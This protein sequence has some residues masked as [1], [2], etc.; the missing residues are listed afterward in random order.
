MIPFEKDKFNI[1]NNAHNNNDHLG[2]NRTYNKI[3]ENGYFLDNI[4]NYI[5]NFIGN[6][7]NWIKIKAG[8]KP[9]QRQK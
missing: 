1:L 2:I 5:K 7:P 6:C 8:K 4:I 9:M 3:K